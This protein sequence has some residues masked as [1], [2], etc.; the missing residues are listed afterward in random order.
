MPYQLFFLCLTNIFVQIFFSVQVEARMRVISNKLED[1]QKFQEAEVFTKT[2]DSSRLVRL[3]LE[4]FLN[5]GVSCN[6]RLTCMAYV[7]QYL[8]SF[9]VLASLPTLSYILVQAECAPEQRSGR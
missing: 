8:R 3:Y 9:A 4:A 6:E 1:E 2:A 5:P 7:L